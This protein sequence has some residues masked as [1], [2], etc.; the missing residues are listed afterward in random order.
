[1][2]LSG[3]KAVYIGIENGFTIGR[4]IRLVEEYYN[5]GARYITLCHTENNDICDSSTDKG[6]PEHGGLSEFG[7]EVVKEMNRLGM[8]VDV[9]HISDDAFYDVLEVSDAPVIASHS[10]ARAVRDNP[11]NLTD[12][13]LVKLAKAGGV[14]QLC[15]LSDYVAATEPFPERDSA[16]M[17]VR[18]RYGGWND[19]NDSTRNLYIA[20]WYAVDEVYPPNLANVAQFC[21]HVDHIVNLIGIDHVGFG[22]DFDGGAGL[23]DCFDVSELPNITLELLKRGYSE[24]DLQKFW[25]SNLLRVMKEVDKAAASI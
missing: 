21:D 14:I 6:G 11:R 4:D 20:D 8:M 1:M 9:S 3:K 2:A 13:M 5:R 18:R 19:L 15:V 25:S 16:K 22:S 17:E 12:D 23:E 7:H 24:S 10:N